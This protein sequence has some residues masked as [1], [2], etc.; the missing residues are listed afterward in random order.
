MLRKRIQA[1]LLLLLIIPCFA[2]AQ[3]LVDMEAEPAGLESNTTCF[4][5]HTNQIYTYEND[6]TGDIE[7][8]AMNPNFILDSAAFHQGVHRHFACTDCHSPE[9]ESFPH[10]SE[11]RLEPMYSCIDCH[12]GDETYAQY[13]FELIEEEFSKSVHATHNGENFD[14][15]MCH[16]PHAYKAMTRGDFKI[17]EIVQNHN[18]TCI[19]CHNDPIQFQLVTDSLRPDLALVHDFIPNYNLHLKSVRCIECHTSQQDTMWVAHQILEKEFAVK[20]CVDCHS[21]N[22]MLMASLYKYQNLEAR[23]DGFLNAVIL[24]N[25]YVI[26]ANRNYIFNIISIVLFGFALLAI[27]IHVY[28]RFKNR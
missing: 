4:E 3:L 14:C 6:W 11:A 24:N 26:G 8:K 19:S 10:P 23:Q 5:C 18:Q 25:S 2:T 12:G 21:S 15:W 9:F 20:K 27:A 1:L 16:D 7:R 17:S 28:F 13:Q 22:T